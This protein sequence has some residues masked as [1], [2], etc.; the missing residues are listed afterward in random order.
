MGVFDFLKDVAL[1]G[2]VKG[3]PGI[4]DLPWKTP[5][6]NLV[7]SFVDNVIRD[8]V[9]SPV[10]GSVVYCDLAAGQAEHS[11][12][13]IGDNRIVHLN[14]DGSIESVTPKDFMDRL[15][16]LNTAISVYVSCGSGA[17]VGSS[18]AAKL[19]KSMIGRRREYSLVFDNCH[20]FTAGCLSGD[21]ENACNFFAFLKDEVRNRIG[22]HEWRVWDF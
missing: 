10:L 14:G 12:I 5:V 13:Y 6:D 16:G 2:I 20:Q 4:V 11:G 22:G 21:F 3:G 8:K 19:A 7:E 17:P 9:S 1:G 18:D 15:G